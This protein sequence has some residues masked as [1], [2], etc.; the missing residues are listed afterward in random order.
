MELGDLLFSLVQLARWEGIDPEAALRRSTRKFIS[1][2]RWME[3]ALRARDTRPGL[4]QPSQQQPGQQQTGQQEPSQWW[5]L[6]NEAKTGA[7][8]GGE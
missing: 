5:A 8:T 1:R 4:Q 2:F 7:K 3:E 6:W